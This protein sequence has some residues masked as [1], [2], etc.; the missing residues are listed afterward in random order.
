M[1]NLQ[2]GPY[3]RCV[4]RCDNDVPDHQIVSLQ[5]ADQVTANFSMEAFTHYH[6][7][8]TR[9]M[10]SMGDLVGDEQDLL[11]TDFRTGEQERW[12]V[13]EHAEL[14]SGHGGG[15]WGLLRDW[16]SAVDQQ[17]PSLLTSTLAAS[18]ESHLMGFMAEQSRHNRTVESVEI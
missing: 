13:R 2:E 9:V 5:F 1:K 18:M 4:Y 15:D 10:G 3:G 7:R 6:G 12:N 17:D 16:L 11:V 14:D 8:R